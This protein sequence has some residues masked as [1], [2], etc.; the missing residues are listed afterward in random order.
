MLEW[1]LSRMSSVRVLPQNPRWPHL[2]KE[3]TAPTGMLYYYLQNH[4]WNTLPLI[5]AATNI[6][7]ACPRAG[8]MFVILNS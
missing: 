6:K 5:S 8:D 4:E 1:T 7:S 2:P 3:R